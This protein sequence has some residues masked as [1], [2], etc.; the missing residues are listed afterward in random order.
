MLTASCSYRLSCCLSG[1]VIK[2]YTM[3]NLYYLLSTV[4]VLLFTPLMLLS[5]FAVPITWYL[6]LSSH[7]TSASHH[8]IP[9]P[10]TTWYLSLSSHDS[11]PLDLYKLSKCKFVCY[12]N[13]ANN[14]IHYKILAKPV[15][16]FHAFINKIT[17]WLVIK[18]QGEHIHGV[19]R[20]SQDVRVWSR[21]G[22]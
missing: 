9:W 20:C 22:Q 3:V 7:D 15:P 16:F 6:S 5:Y 19:L 14:F 13:I 2:L 10:L 21:D 8:M 4:L 17:D 12:K 11:Q 18:A 1:T